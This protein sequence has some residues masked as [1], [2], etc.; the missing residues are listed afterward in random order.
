MLKASVYNR[1]EEKYQTNSIETMDR[2]NI[3][4]IVGEAGLDFFTAY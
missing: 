2:T 4:F 1:G 3:P